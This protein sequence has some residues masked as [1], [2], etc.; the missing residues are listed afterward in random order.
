M[1]HLD[2]VPKNEWTASQVEKGREA[3]GGKGAAGHSRKGVY[4]QTQSNTF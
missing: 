4:T 2:C 1:Q 3:G